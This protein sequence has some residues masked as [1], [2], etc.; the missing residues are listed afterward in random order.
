MVLAIAAAV[1]LVAV[2][3][4]TRLRVETNHIGFFARTHPLSRSAAVIDGA[5]A[6]VYSFNILLEGPADSMKAPDTVRRID[7]LST[8]IARMPEVRKATSMADHVKRA[9]QELHNG[10]PGAA[11]VPSDP[12]VIAQ[13]LFLIALTDEGRREL[14]RVVSSDFS[15]AQIVVRM[16]SMSSGKVYDLIQEAQRL[17]TGIFEGSPVKATA[18]GSGRL[19]S[20]LDHY[21]V[22]SQISSFATAFLTIFAV[23][24]LIFRSIRF[25]FLALVPN[26]LPVVAVLGVMGWLGITINIATVMVASVALGVVDDDTVH[27]LH[28]FRRQLGGGGGVEAAARIAATVEGRAAFTTALINSCGFAVLMLSEYQPSAWFGGLLALTLGMAFV[29]EVFVAAGDSHGPRTLSDSAAGT[30]AGI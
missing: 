22:R 13:E 5:L 4:I 26:L 27:F 8:A 7:Q 25:G 30:C 9:N 10:S 19:F 14:A 21:V 29:A 6:G 18:A 24:F 12:L 16:P 11:V 15:T 23:M 28:R 20:T 17:A 2:V 3:G 1:V